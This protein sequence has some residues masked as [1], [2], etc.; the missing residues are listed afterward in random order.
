MIP[1]SKIENPKLE[2]DSAEC[3]GAGGS[4]DSVKKIRNPK[5][6]TRNKFKCSNAQISKPK[7]GPDSEFLG[8]LCLQWF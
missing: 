3:F 5:L 2:G 7:Y 1:Q 6:E 4:G 8:F